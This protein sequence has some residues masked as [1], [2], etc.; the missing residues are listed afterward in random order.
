M[1]WLIAG[2]ALLVGGGAVALAGV[3]R[4]SD[5]DVFHPDHTRVF[6]GFQKATS[7]LVGGDG[8][9][10]V[11]PDSEC[12]Q[13]AESLWRCYRRWAPAGNPGAA[14][15]LEAD[16]NVYDDRIVVGEIGRTADPG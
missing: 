12:K 6:N 7:D 8:V 13:V 10:S 16:V 2:V 11:P 1:K 9:S 15:I 4:P 5:E 3:N 14:E